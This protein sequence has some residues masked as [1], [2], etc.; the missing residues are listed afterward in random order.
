MRNPDQLPAQTALF[1]AGR[2]IAVFMCQPPAGAGTPYPQ[3]TAFD[4]LDAHPLPM[5]PV[6][7]ELAV[8]G[9]IAGNHGGTLHLQQQR[10]VSSQQRRC[11]ARP[12]QGKR[13]GSHRQGLG[14]RARH[15]GVDHLAH[16]VG[17]ITAGL[18]AQL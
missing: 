18:P 2:L 14:V 10:Q 9:V 4:L 1:C 6:I 7:L 16:G 17:A 15:I 5:E 12:D 8:T 3:G 11:P 13:P